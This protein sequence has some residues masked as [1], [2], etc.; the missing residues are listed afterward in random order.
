MGILWGITVLLVSSLGPS[1]LI[2]G[3]YLY[4]APLAQSYCGQ[5]M[6]G[7]HRRCF[8]LQTIH[9]TLPKT[10]ELVKHQFWDCIQAW[11]AWHWA[12]CIMLEL[13]EVKTSNYD[14]FN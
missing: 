7:L 3:S 2:Q 6:E 9:L 13:C 1:P 12:A 5:Q 14:S 10:S 11:R 4:V 8:H